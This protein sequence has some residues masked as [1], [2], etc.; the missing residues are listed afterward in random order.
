MA[1]TNQHKY[2]PW[3][4]A[5]ALLLVSSG[6]L[7][8][9]LDHELHQHDLPCALHLYAG[10]VGTPTAVFVF[11]VSAPAETPDAIPIPAAPSLDSPRPYAVRAPP[12]FL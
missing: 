10:Q 11:T 2:L 9:E 4:L 7:S 5:A 12:R 3:L 8:H 6:A 1:P